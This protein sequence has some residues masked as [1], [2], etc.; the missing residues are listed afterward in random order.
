MHLHKPRLALSCVPAD[1]QLPRPDQLWSFVLWYDMNRNTLK[2]T[3][4]DHDSLYK[5][6][7]R[8][9]LICHL[10]CSIS[11][12]TGFIHFSVTLTFSHLIRH[13]LIVQSDFSLGGASSGLSFL[14]LNN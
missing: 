10:I 8:Q 14:V 9:V 13:V 12:E 2:H 5:F 6:Q 7:S 4:A 1:S 3:R 11:G